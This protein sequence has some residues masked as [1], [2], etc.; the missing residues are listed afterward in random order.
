MAEVTNLERRAGS[1]A[2][3]PVGADV[4]IGVT[5]ARNRHN[6]NGQDHE[7]GCDRSFCLREPDAGNLPRRTRKRAA[8]GSS[9]ADWSE[10]LRPN[11]INNVLAFLERPPGIFFRGAH[12][13]ARAIP[14]RRCSVAAAHALVRAVHDRTPT[15]NSEDYI[16]PKAFRPPRRP[17]RCKKNFPC[18]RSRKKK[19]RSK[20]LRNKETQPRL[21]IPS[22]GCAVYPSEIHIKPLSEIV[23][24][25]SSS[26]A[27]T[28]IIFQPATEGAG[29]QIHRRGRRAPGGEWSFVV[30]LLLLQRGIPC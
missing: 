27:R 21:G 15:M 14:T 6:G 13:R 5:R 8:R 9:L 28:D 20:A 1:L 29:F 10:R 23:Q 30:L 2:D 16:I 25:I 18:R 4:F 22:R 11:Q 12:R 24:G 17:C 3:M 7:Q 26:V 19:R